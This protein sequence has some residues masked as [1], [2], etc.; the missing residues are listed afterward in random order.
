MTKSVY[1][2]VLSD[3]VVAAIDEMA[4][5]LGTNRSGLI[6]SI[7][8]EK[9]SYVT[10]EQRIKHII[11]MVL[12]NIDGS[13]TFRMLPNSTNLALKSTFRYKYNPTVKYAVTFD[14]KGETLGELKVNLRTQNAVLL[15][16]L[17]SFLN[18]FVGWEKAYLADKL[19]TVVGYRIEPGRFVR[20]LALAENIKT[21]D[22]AAKAVWDYINVFDRVMKRYFYNNGD[23]D[24][25][26]YL[27]EIGKSKYLI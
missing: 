21:D 5:R 6:N 10:P 20:R 27:D 26:V 7:L 25:S 16:E 1:S 9:V 15:D 19:P 24:A 8:A 22:D 13:M 11:D 12:D 4:Y 17:D 3:D 23:I 2:I 14:P 18:L